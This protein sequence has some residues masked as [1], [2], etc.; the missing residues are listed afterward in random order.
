MLKSIRARLLASFIFLI[1]LISA[2]SGYSIYN[3]DISSKG[4]DSYQSM[5]QDSLLAGHFQSNIQMAQLS[6]QDYLNNPGEKEAQAFNA[7]YQNV[8]GDIKTARQKMKHPQ[9]AEMVA[10]ADLKLQDYHKEFEAVQR[11]IAESD[12]LI[13][14]EI[15]AKEP[16]INRLLSDIKV[17]AQRS[18][19]QELFVEVSDSLNSMLTGQLY[20][21]KF[22]SS[23]SRATMNRALRDFRSFN[24][25]LAKLRSLIIDT[26]N[27]QRLA[28]AETLVKQYTQAVSQLYKV[29]NS[30]N[31]HVITMNSLG[32]QI[33]EL[34]DAIKDSIQ[35]DQATVGPEVKQSN[36]Q[37]ITTLIVVSLLVVLLALTIALTIPRSIIKG[38]KSIQHSLA[39]ISDSGDFSLRADSTRED[40]I[41]E[42]GAAVNHLLENL[43]SAIQSANEVVG[44]I[45]QGEFDKRMQIDANGDLQTLKEGVNNS[46]QSVAFMMSELAKVMSALEQGDFDV[47]MDSAVAQGFRDQVEGALSSI[48]KIINNILS[49]MESMQKGEFDTRVE[50][51]A[52]GAL[53]ELKQGINHSM[54]SLDLAVDDLLTVIEAQSQGN[55]AE[56]LTNNYQGKLAALQQAIENT[57]AKLSQVVGNASGASDIVSNAA[58]E[59]ALGA[60]DLSAAM[61]RQA[62]AIEE[63]SATMHEMNSQVQSTSQNAKEV[64]LLTEKMQED[65]N[66]GVGVMQQTIDAM[67]QI[68][69]S[70]NKI[71]DIV[72]L[73]DSIAFQT[74]LLALNA[75]VEAARAGEHGRGFA[76]VAGEVRALAQKSA[77]AAKDIKTLIDETVD[78]V[79]HGSGLASDS[80]A[81]LQQITDS[82]NLVTQMVAQ[83][84]QASLEQSEGIGQVFNSISE[85]DSVTQQNSALVEQTSA[86]AASLTDQAV[87]LNGEMRFFSIENKPAELP[88][89]IVV[90]QDKETSIALEDLSEEPVSKELGF[91]PETEVD[92]QGFKIY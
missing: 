34:G 1:A 59:V 20:T 45:A 75:A 48:D 40:E 77:D 37:L 46:A 69:E 58:N 82:V 84:A 35:A 30:L 4:F 63:T 51:E 52:K 64:A 17:S 9:R 73:I 66:S 22:I 18:G 32:P 80:G 49:V 70:S 6:V 43:Q 57:A 5:T 47:K 74:N 88:Q 27:Q 36:E 13:S 65:A 78:R 72:S 28:E 71:S 33:V 38:L 79:E 89:N 42:M 44:A 54:S 67:S 81:R 15:G 19:N 14:Q 24:R 91:V 29:T 12:S 92:E 26:A 2:L 56:R 60:N 61:Q 11:L 7:F 62:A 8:L 50:I 83:I 53:L 25:K 39:Q 68:E 16:K 76:V 55:L 3:L 87:A 10:Q 90:E 85:I 23:N 21:N 41:G 86:A 31:G